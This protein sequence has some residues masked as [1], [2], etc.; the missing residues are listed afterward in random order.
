MDKH[1]LR[2]YISYA[3]TEHISIFSKQHLK[4]QDWRQY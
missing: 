1:E 3:T 4:S 2:L